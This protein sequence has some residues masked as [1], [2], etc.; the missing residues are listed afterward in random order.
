M[1]TETKAPVGEDTVFE[2]ASLSKPVFAYAVLQLVDEGKLDLDRPLME[3]TTQ[4]YIEENFLRGQL[5]DERFRRLTARMVLSHT[6]GL[7]NWRPRGGALEF[8]RDP[9][10]EFGYSGEGFVFLQKVVEDL[11]G[12]EC[13]AFVGERV[14]EPLGMEH[15][16]YVWREDYEQLAA[17]SHSLF[18]DARPMYKASRANAAAS[19]RTTAADYARFLV[20]VMNGSGLKPETHAAMLTP[21]SETGYQGVSWG[22][23][24]GLQA[25]GSGPSFWHWGDNGDFK[26]FAVAYREEKLGVVYFANSGTGLSVASGLVRSA[27]GGSHPAVDRFVAEDYDLV[28][29]PRF[30]LVAEYLKGGIEAFEREYRRLQTLP[31]NGGATG[32]RFINNAG[33]QL[34]YA[35]RLDDAITVFKLNV[36]A[37]PESFNVYDS[38]GEAYLAR[39]DYDAA[40][41]NYAKSVEL[42]PENE[43]GKRALKRL[44]NIKANLDSADG[45]K[46]YATPEEAGFSSAK[47]ERARSYAVEIGS[48]AVMA[49]YRGR[50]LA[51]WGNVEFP[52]KCHSVRKSFLSGLYGIYV[53]N[54]KIDLSKT[55]AELGIDDEPPLTVVEKGAK[56]GDMIK[57]RSGVY[58]SAAYETQSMKDARPARGSHEPGTFWYY[59][60]WD[61]NTLGAIF[62]S[63]TGKD[64]F[65]AF[66][67]HF[68]VPLAMKDFDQRLCYYHLEKENSIYPAYPFRMSARDMARYG[69]LY[70]QDGEWAGE[71][72]LPRGWVAESSASYSDI[73]GGAGYGYMWWT[74]PGEV[75]KIHGA[76][77][78]GEYFSYSARGNGGHVITIVPEAEMVFIHRTD[79]DRRKRVSYDK[80]YSLLDMILA[81]QE[82]EPKAEPA[83]AAMSPVRWEA[84]EELPKLR[85]PIDL[86][87]AT[88]DA[89]VGSYDLGEGQTLVITKEDD[90]LW[91][92][93]FGQTAELF[94]ESAT[95]FF[96]R[97]ADLVCTFHK[98]E[99]GKVTEVVM[100]YEGRVVTA[101]KI[102]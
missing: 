53:G 12:M 39:K 81:A 96:I 8:V 18:G 84:E 101:P 66:G 23:G 91:L 26:A 90:R 30:G 54:N 64:I 38:L 80:V 21:Q 17:S 52:Y 74:M 60:N 62:R 100:D 4:Q 35:R 13:N 34:L 67:E 45:W 36:E 31:E 20:A 71:R 82:S 93:A 63:G 28:G 42:N 37:F 55:L 7:P 15:S 51:A 10:V 92:A 1:S 77:A 97:V 69:Q 76:N 73:G 5:E 102:E 78:L 27:L 6:T 11:T 3:Y 87:P 65:A 86:D 16:S 75:A 29:T 32:E 14:F 95:V 70:L 58:H 57:A 24:I 43:G 99:E 61:F 94:P 88:Y 68:A 33:Y 56:I 40:I 48:A 89:Y 85:I 72:I 83:L 9:G 46:Q 25:S 44:H 98:D 41:E 47:L 2:A 22:L 59:N 79:T 49:V 19:L 50:V